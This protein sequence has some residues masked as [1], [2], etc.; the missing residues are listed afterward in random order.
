MTKFA[1]FCRA[2][3][4][5]SFG[6]AVGMFWGIAPG[7]LFAQE[8]DRQH[9]GAVLQPGADS[10][11]GVAPTAAELRNAL[12]A[13]RAAD[14]APDKTP[15]ALTAEE[16]RAIQSAYD[17][18]AYARAIMLAQA[19]L[20]KSPKNHE[21][22]TIIGNAYLLN[23]APQQAI[24]FLARAAQYGANP[25]QN[26]AA[27]CLSYAS[28]SRGGLEDDPTLAACMNA[29]KLNPQNAALQYKAAQLLSAANRHAE[30]VDF[31]KK[32]RDLDG[33]NLSYLTALTSAL[34]HA[35]DNI[36]AYE[37]TVERIGQKPIAILFHNAAIYA[38][39]AGMYEKSAEWAAKGYELF[40]DKSFLIAVAYAQFGMARYADA[41]ETVQSLADAQFSAP[42]DSRYALIRAKTLFSNLRPEALEDFDS[43][44]NNRIAQ[45]DPQYRWMFALS[46]VLGKKYGEA[47]RYADV[48]AGSKDEETHLMAYLIQAILPLFETNDTQTPNIKT[49]RSL[50]VSVKVNCANRFKLAENSASLP[51][52]LDA[53]ISG[54]PG[55]G[56]PQVFIDAVQIVKQHKDDDYP[57]QPT[58]LCSARTRSTS[59]PAGVLAV[60]GAA[61]GMFVLRRRKHG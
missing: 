13:P 25:A 60:L 18:K 34:A 11:G 51:G 19:A 52:G 6:A 1:Y 2:G 29:A 37:L 33:S 28:V 44:K 43:L 59:A 50:P 32:A 55:R 41:L 35:G 15:S 61:F 39:R 49:W 36:A 5:L 27:L 20:E 58:G 9:N 21:L 31:L 57:K 26:Q 4:A 53:L 8:S 3:R 24:P 23:G 17:E 7:A 40:N 48:M 14:A 54:L 38:Q 30:A 12:T 56:M 16:L 46:F 22:C 45:G 47:R 10:D 42:Y